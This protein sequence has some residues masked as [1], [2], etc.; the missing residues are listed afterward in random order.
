MLENYGE[1]YRYENVSDTM[2]YIRY[3]HDAL[4][5]ANG[6]PPLGLK[7]YANKYIDGNA[8][9]HEKLLQ[10]EKTDIVKELNSKLK[11]R[12]GITLKEIKDIFSDKIL[13]YSDL[14]EPIR[15]RYLDWLSEDV[16]I[17]IQPKVD[18]L[19]T[20]DMIPYNVLNRENIIK[21]GHYDIIYL[22][23]IYLHLTW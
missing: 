22:L 14:K 10:N 3:A 21:Y 13:D 5:P 23:E 7:E 8:K 15:T 18:S 12:L 2:F 6:G 1:P 11:M 19:I 16:P 17:Y 4:T 20:P 9:Y